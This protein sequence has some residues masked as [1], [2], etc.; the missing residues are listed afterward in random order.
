[1]MK[2]Y[3]L[4]RFIQ[5]GYKA[6]RIKRIMKLSVICTFC[7]ALSAV[8]NEAKAYPADPA[9]SIGVDA[10]V[11]TIS[12]KGK[13][14]D[15]NGEAVIGASILEKGTTNG[16]IT[17]MD[18]QFSINVGTNA[19]LVVSYIGYVSYEKKVTSSQV[20]EITLEEDSKHLEEVVVV[21]YGVQKKSV[22]TAAISRVTSKE[23]SKSTPT[24]IED[25][26]KGKVSGVQITQN[27]GQPGAE[28]KVRIRG[29]GTINNSN[30]L[31][32]V[33]GMPI[34]SGI[35]Y[36]N[37]KDIE[38][39][40]VLKD[41]A[42]AAIY[43]ARAANG[44][45]LVTT[46]QGKVGKASINYSF[47]YGIQSPWRTRKLLNGQEYEEI[48]NE[49]YT[50]AG[51]TPLYDD[52]SKAGKGTDWQKLIVND[53]APVINHNA[54][55]NGGNE[56]NRYFISFGYLDQEGI[57]AKGKSDYKRYN[58]RA[59]SSHT[60][61]EET[62][63]SFLNKLRVGVNVGYSK[64]EARGI[65]D[66]NNFGG[67]LFGATLAPP[68]L[69]L[70]ETDQSEI[71]RLT[72]RYGD[73]LVK[74]EQGRLY[75][76]I[77]GS[78]LS[79]P[80]ALMQTINQR[81]DYHKL[82][83]SIWGELDIVEGLTLRSSY[84]T[85]LAFSSETNWSP[86]YYLSETVMDDVS[87]ISANKWD[88]NTWNVENTLKYNKS[89]GVHNLSAMVGMSMQKYSNSNISGNN[90]NLIADVAGKDYLDSALGTKK[91]QETSGGANEHTMASGFGRINYNF[92]ERYLA[93]FV[94]R[95]DGSS[96]FSKNN[97]W[98]YFPSASFGWNVHN[99]NFFPENS[100][101]SQL[102][103]RAS[104]GK[105]GNENIGAFQYT[106]LINAGGSYIFN[107]ETVSGMY[108]I[109]LMNNQIRW[110]E[111]E[112][113]DLGFDARFF[114]NTLSATV[115]VF[116]KKTNGMLM[117][118]PIPDYVGNDV[119]DGNVG[120]MINKGIEIELSYQ[121]NIGDFEYSIGANASYMKNKIDDIGVASGYMDYTS[122]NT[123]GVVQ[124]H[125]TGYPV[126]HYFGTPAIGIF[127]TQEQVNNYKNS[128][129]ELLQ[130]DAKP[131]D[132]IFKDANKDGKINDDDRT[133]LGKP[134]PDW[135]VG[136]NMN[137]NYK[138]FD[139][140]MFWQGAFGGKIF[141][142][143]RR[144]DLAHVNYSTYI[145]DRWHGEGTSNY[146]PRVVYANAESN[147][148]WRASNL[149]LYNG[150][151]MRLKNLIVGYTLPREFVQKFLC[152]EL[153]FYV[154]AENLVTLTKYHGGDPEIGGRD[155]IDQGV[156]PQAR[157]ITFGVSITF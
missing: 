152:K 111:S 135:A 96:N 108:P 31:Y 99:E 115:D 110:E 42:S 112:Q 51:M 2:N 67:P 151:Y 80:V 55:I 32:I 9:V 39:V 74:D 38:S 143:S 131:G 83:G 93:E 14:V 81:K 21:G 98:A 22:V 75:K 12:I 150:N 26:L 44:V 91:D 118:L 53:K 45:I 141:D 89:F 60:V 33:D 107:N 128:R 73:M 17:D 125:T 147:N 123:L 66:N 78:E 62:G 129:G 148:N 48:M 72:E 28:S 37:P 102:K 34:S 132:V 27:S 50:N 68:N 126:A 65:S 95:R 154:Q 29:I 6:N 157:T 4:D 114:N 122:F 35:D 61:F 40:E 90:I 101:L 103:I 109:K 117:E 139:F 155:G 87:R 46:K 92:N 120:S 145:L 137:M 47:S 94:L 36:L 20:L 142:I 71:D 138:G 146:Y 100:S 70:Y 133:Y 84:S 59:N 156:Y 11:E 144:P 23:L 8:A 16:V 86:A 106:S 54:S 119:P 113:Y 153:R 134:N 18:G 127:Q 5:P 56:K 25:V 13:V 136:F 69:P 63:R 15:V 124:R 82:V 85:D 149:Y 130:P 105:N 57:I 64:I 7:F 1:M 116:Y 88:H 97:K 77:S 52:P 76:I 41:A 24:R 19:T 30:P 43:G 79:N 49:A 104:W 140:S 10:V 58:F 121:N 3:H